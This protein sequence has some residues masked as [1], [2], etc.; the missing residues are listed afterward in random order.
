[1]KVIAK[2]RMRAKSMQVTQIDRSLVNITNICADMLGPKSK[3]LKYKCKKAVHK[4]F[5]QKAACKMVKLTT[6]L[7]PSKLHLEPNLPFSLLSFKM[8]FLKI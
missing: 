6:W 3:N 7:V 2:L 4:T 8:T 1:M 5:V